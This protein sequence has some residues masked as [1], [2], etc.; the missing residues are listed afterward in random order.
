[1]K[2]KIS[3]LLGLAIAVFLLAVSFTVLRDQ[4][5][6]YR[7]ADIQRS[8]SNI[9]NSQIAA[10]FAFTLLGLW[11]NDRLRCPGAAIFATTPKLPAHGD[12]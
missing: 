5:Q 4:I 3:T 9:S 2:Q 6:D 7:L 11:C 10:S 8:F 12:G 1:M